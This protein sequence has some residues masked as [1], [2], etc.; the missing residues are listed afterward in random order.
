MTK[1]LKFKNSSRKLFL[2]LMCMFLACGFTG[3]GL[4]EDDEE[5]R[6]SDGSVEVNESAQRAST[7]LP[8]GEVREKKVKLKGDGTD[9][10]TVLVYMNGSNLESDD[11][12][13]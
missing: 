1:N 5:A 7:F 9:T 3:C 2:F 13:E 8:D 4:F 12:E 11:N 10:V 6:Y